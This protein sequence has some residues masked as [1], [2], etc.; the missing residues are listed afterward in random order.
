MQPTI[1]ADQG[2]SAEKLPFR[3]L[4]FFER[5]LEAHIA[6]DVEDNDSLWL[7]ESGSGEASAFAEF[8]QRRFCHHRRE[9]TTAQHRH[10]M[11]AR[12]Q[13]VLSFDDAWIS[14]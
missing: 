13:H 8:V 9:L 12:R 11:A 5:F 4:V 6:R 7:H 2:C 1:A 3:H 10:Q 14:G